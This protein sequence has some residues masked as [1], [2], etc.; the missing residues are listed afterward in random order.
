[1]NKYILSFLSVLVLLFIVILVSA[2]TGSIEVGVFDFIKGLFTGTDE[3]VNI[4]K[5]LRL[6]RVIIA[7]YSGAALAVAGV[8]FQAVMKNPLA[9]AGVIGISSGAKLASLLGITI[10]P[11]LFYY[12]PLFSFA[13]GVLACFLVY[14]FSWKSH[15]SPVKIILV[16][17][18]IN[19]M[20]T[21]LNESF[22]TICNYLGTIPAASS[23]SSITQ[24]TWGDVQVIA[25]YGTVGIVLS[26]FI[27]SWCNLLSL[28]D[29][30]ARNL[31]LH[32]TRAR[33]LISA[34]AVWLAAVAT[35]IAGVIAFVGLLIPHISRRIVGSDHKVL[36]PFSA[37][38]GAL[39]ILTADTL[40]R[41]VLAP[42]EIP[43]STIMAVIGGPFLIFFLRKQDESYGN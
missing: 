20:F 14:S 32:V 37:L 33:L 30:T 13:G 38:A 35:S 16:G 8:L 24:K 19:A 34:I 5:D 9:D 43:A 7:L 31:G 3:N 36:I 17:I 25:S 26:L 4:I 40:G 11:Q 21:G 15:L 6:P 42:S 1:M 41:T 12:M 22:I 18:A 29:K 27:G 23:S 28:Q 2:I 10:F 39:L